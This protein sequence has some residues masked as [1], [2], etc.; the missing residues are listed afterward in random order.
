MIS[1]ELLEDVAILT[2]ANPPVNAVSGAVANALSAAIDDLVADPSVRAIV[3][4]GRGN[5]FIGGADI[6][7]LSSVIE[8]T[9][10]LPDLNSFLFKI[11]QSPKPVV[12]AISGPAL[13]GGL[14]TAM[15]A[16]YRL[17]TPDAALGQPEVNLGL[18]PGMGG[19]QRL[20]R[21]VGVRKALQMCVTG[22]PL[23]AVQAHECGLVDEVVE[24]DL[25]AAAVQF[26]H[27]VASLPPRKTSHLPCEPDESAVAEWRDKAR[28]S[29][30]C[31]EA[32]LA[33][34]EAIAAACQGF[35]H[36]FALEQQQF[37]RRLASNQAR[38]MLHIFFG[39][40]TVAKI[41]G[42]R[43]ENPPAEI[44]TAGVLGAGFMGSGIA[45]V[46]ANAGIAVQLSDVSE[47]AL[48]RA[49]EIVQKRCKRPELV[50]T[51]SDLNAF[52]NVDIAIEAVIESLEA[53]QQAFA[54]LA[55]FVS[56]DC[57]LATNTSTLDIDEIA[58]GVKERS[59]GVVGLHFFSPAHVM[60]L[61]EV[62]R[63]SQ[64]S[65][66]T[67]LTAMALSKRL[68]KIS[69]LARNAFGFIGNRM[70]LP[71]LREAHKLVEEGVT[72]AQINRALYNF[73]MPMGP[74]AM[75]DLV[76]LDVTYHMRQEA[77]RRGYVTGPQPRIADLLYRTGRYGQKS[78]IGWSNYADRRNP[79]PNPEISD[80][81][82][83]SQRQVSDAEIVDRCTGALVAEGKKVVAEGVALRPVD[84]D[85]VYVH[86]FGF[87]AWRGGPL[88][89]SDHRSSD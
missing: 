52:K 79:V 68:G 55:S 50:T 44:A 87:P 2:V 69:V 74:L 35:E 76:G 83:G 10:Q 77:T 46:L 12:A 9:S 47:A 14:E 32:P 23:S 31:E 84:V 6:K 89:W 88:F 49:N 51:V 67:V 21:L 64:T 65:D 1:I 80:L 59:D 66:E 36:G 72:V 85:I 24:T 3:L 16:H 63:A 70:V 86:G 4:R 27:K 41:P 15:A 71:Y 18:I 5:L 75:E 20:P 73:G 60:K 38:A 39:E 42:L 57:I 19:T 8:G 13:G 7:M 40:R 34:V 48:L 43:A 17:A 33:A 45:V 82:G 37:R 61:V 81:L 54:S 28:K 56:A 11:E 30:R 29:R 53:K 26:A 78:G 25:A 22:E 62:V 58:A